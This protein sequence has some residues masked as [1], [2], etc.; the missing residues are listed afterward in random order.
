MI[1][2]VAEKL[3]AIG[4]PF[5]LVS[6]YIGPELQKPALA[7]APRVEK[8]VNPPRLLLA[9]TDAVQASRPH[10]CSTPG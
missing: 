2:P 3:R 7:D 1:T 8:P 6:G 5:V 10:S 4:V 9:L